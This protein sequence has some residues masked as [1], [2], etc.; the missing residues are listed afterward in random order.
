MVCTSL[1]YES[2]VS[3]NMGNTWY[4]NSLAYESRVSQNM[5]NT[6]YALLWHMS[7]E[8]HKTWGNTWYANSFEVYRWM[9]GLPECQET[10]GR[11]ELV[12]AY[13]A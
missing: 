9:R 6:W 12:S 4:D 7:Q 2:R 5:G 3:Q 11:E 13:A 1:A 8:F 10:L